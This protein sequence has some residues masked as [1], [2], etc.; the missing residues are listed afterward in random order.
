MGALL[1]SAL[2]TAMYM[3]TI[4]V[5]AFFPGK[6]FDYSTIAD[7][8]DPGW[9]MLLPLVIFVLVIVVFG[10]HAGPFLEALQSV[11]SML[12]AE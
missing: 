6:D 3:L 12:P 8:K 5:R 11:A 10:M 4:S 7:A 9:M 1:A 2:L